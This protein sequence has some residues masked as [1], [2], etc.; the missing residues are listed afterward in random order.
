MPFTKEGKRRELTTPE[1][2]RIIEARNRGATWREIENDFPVTARGAKK[3]FD[4]SMETKSLRR[5]KH[6]QTKEA[7]YE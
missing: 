2:A 5:T 6:K 4:R 7:Q 1:R 3:V